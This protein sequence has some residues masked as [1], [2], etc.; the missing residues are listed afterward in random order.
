MSGRAPSEM[1]RR[2]RAYEEEQRAYEQ[3][4]GT[5]SRSGFP[6]GQPERE[7]IAR[8]LFGNPTPQ[9]PPTAAAHMPAFPLPG[10]QRTLASQFRQIAEAQ[11]TKNPP[12]ADIPHELVGVRNI[13]RSECPAGHYHFEGV[14]CMS[15]DVFNEYYRGWTLRKGYNNRVGGGTRSKRKPT[16]TN[17][18]DRR[19]RSTGRRRRTR[20]M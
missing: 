13:P 7:S 12:Y 3:G 1:D 10:R 14:G 15:P 20:R 2:I 19:R 18:T 6:W 8:R 5:T 17:R 16:R 4:Q 11:K 9:R